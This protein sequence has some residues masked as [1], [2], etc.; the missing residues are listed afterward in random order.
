MSG[1]THRPETDQPSFPEGTVADLIVARAR[2]VPDAVAVAQWDEKI[3]Y[4]ELTGRAT[5]LSARLRALGVGPETKVGICMERRPALLV[6]L[7]GVLLSSG[8]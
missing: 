7:L 3:T 5:A 8:T 1:L 4:R 2:A 6:A